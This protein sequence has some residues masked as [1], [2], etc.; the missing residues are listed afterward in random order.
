MT[1]LLVHENFL[2]VNTIQ[3]QVNPQAGWPKQM[4]PL[5][6]PHFV[7]QL[8]G[9]H[10]FTA[11]K[12]DAG[13]GGFMIKELRAFAPGW[14]VRLRR[15][16]APVTLLGGAAAAAAAATWAARAATAWAPLLL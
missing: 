15:C 11:K 12:L 2:Q 4:P 9:V 8:N 16:A 3:P 7:D 1:P 5:S 6:A 10:G 14:M 13:A